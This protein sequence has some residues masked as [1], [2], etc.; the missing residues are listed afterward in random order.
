VRRKTGGETTPD[1][2]DQYEQSYGDAQAEGWAPRRRAEDLAERSHYSSQRDSQEDR[3]G[4]RRG[5][6]HDVESAEFHDWGSRHARGDEAEE[7]AEDED[8]ASEPAGT[9]SVTWLERRRKATRRA[10]ARKAGA[11]KA[12]ARKKA[13]ARKAA[14]RKTTGRKAGARAPKRKARPGSRAR[15]RR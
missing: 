6:Q 14:P 7:P 9:E 11:R 12:G 1:T 15:R 8:V 10:A 4:F 3:S 2:K 5:Y 13:A